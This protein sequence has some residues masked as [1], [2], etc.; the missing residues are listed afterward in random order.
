MQSVTLGPA[1][2]P[3]PDTRRRDLPH[4]V[5]NGPK[6]CAPS[7][8]QVESRLKVIFHSVRA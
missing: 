7:R 8:E 5:E 2:P 3:S 6:F 1:P 4:V